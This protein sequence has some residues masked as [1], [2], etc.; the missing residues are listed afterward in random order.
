MIAPLRETDS[1]LDANAR[2]LARARRAVAAAL[3]RD[4]R[5]QSKQPQ[6]VTWQAW[7]FAIWTLIVASSSLGLIVGWWKLVPY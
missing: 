3:L 1:E 2:L 5:G 7:L 6:L 4:S